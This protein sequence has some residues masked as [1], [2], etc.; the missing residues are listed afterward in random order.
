MKRRIL[1][2][3]L[4]LTAALL[5][6]GCAMRTAEEMYALPRRSQ[7][8]SKL[9][10]AIDSAMEGKTYSAPLFGDNRQTVQ[11]ADLD[12]DGR[13]EYLIFA[14]DN[15]T[16]PLKVLIFVETEN[17]DCHLVETIESN[18]SAFEQVEYVEFD[19]R[20][21]C[22]LVIG[23]QVSDQVLRSV[24]VY[25]FRGGSA[26]QLLLIGY[27]KFMTCD[28]DQNGHSELLVLRPG[29]A[30][31]QRGMAV[32]YSSSG[33][34]V[35]RS[36]EAELSRDPSSIRRITL[37][38]L[39]CKTPAVFVASAVDDSAIVTDIF[40]LREERFTNIAFSGDADTSIG[41]LRNYYVY[42]EDIDEDGILELPGLINMKPI[43]SWKED[44]QDFLLR[45]FSVDV[46][47]R[48]M[49]K[50]YTFHN[51]VDGWYM[52]LPS[53]LATRIT[54]DQRSGIYYF[55]V[56]DPAHEQASLLFTVYVLSGSTRDEDAVSEGRFPL[57]RTETAAY[58]AK[59]ESGAAEYN[60]T[61][62]ELVSCFHLIRQD[63]RNGE[64]Q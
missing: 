28:L 46:G 19:D 47:G 39:Q 59:L 56:W 43:S 29:E 44:D 18:G 54:V 1:L 15:S 3:S 9:Q 34:Q 51:F 53:A 2:L 32:L 12:G 25:R 20:P 36:L 24:S 60:I 55:N 52:E 8:Y 33:G 11:M 23:R 13:D 42:A 14:A 49:D 27:S 4:L 21:G 16:R 50:R 62:E 26:E 10:S 22:E 64:T 37:G 7:E 57:Y 6:G 38:T 41:T 48:E 61:E 5:L 40:A 45:W 63:W 17:G 30:E 31:S 35:R 58:A